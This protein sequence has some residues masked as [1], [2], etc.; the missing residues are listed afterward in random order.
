MTG[1]GEEDRI[2]R[3]ALSCVAEPGDEVMGTLLQ[4]CPPAEIVAALT[5]GRMPAAT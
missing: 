5:E 1:A 4:T 2:A 3:A